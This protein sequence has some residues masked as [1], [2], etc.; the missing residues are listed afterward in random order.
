L[1]FTVVLCSRCSLFENGPASRTPHAG[2]RGRDDRRSPPDGH[3]AAPCGR[4]C[5]RSCPW[6]RSGSPSGVRC[7]ALYRH[8]GDLEILGPDPSEASGPVDQGAVLPN[9]M[10]A[11]DPGR[12]ARG[13]AACPRAWTHA[14]DGPGSVERACGDRGPRGFRDRD[15]SLVESVRV[16]TMSRA[17]STA[18]VSARVRSA[19][20]D[21]EAFSGH[22]TRWH[23]T[24]G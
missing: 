13:E 16:L 9:L 17:A 23:Q 22:S 2:L 8:V 10:N 15:H 6:A 24:G 11:G 18:R 3:G 7:G 5:W 21:G 19:S 14:D 12:E 1:P 20:R 4:V